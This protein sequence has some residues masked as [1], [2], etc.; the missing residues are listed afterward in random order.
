[1]IRSYL[2]VSVLINVALCVLITYSRK[3]VTYRTGIV[4]EIS[5]T[6][7]TYIRTNENLWKVDSRIVVVPL[8]SGWELRLPPDVSGRKESTEIIE[9]TKRWMTE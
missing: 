6:L 9:A 5:P 7:E 4:G 8:S 1:M 3:S 2:Y